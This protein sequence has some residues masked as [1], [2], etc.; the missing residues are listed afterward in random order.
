MSN[1]DNMKL[2]ILVILLF[3]AFSV[4]GQDTI[5]KMINSKTHEQTIFDVNG[6]IVEKGKLKLLPVDRNVFKDDNTC[7][8]EAFYRHG[9]W[10]EYYENGNK[11]RVVIYEKG[12]IKKVP[13]S[14]NEDGSRN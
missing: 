2:S 9:K 14:W 5:R 4:N 3:T 13:R 12:L 8:L 11:K 1:L 10:I 6:Q 7:I